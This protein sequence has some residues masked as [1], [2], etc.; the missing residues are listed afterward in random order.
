MHVIKKVKICCYTSTVTFSLAK[1][2]LKIRGAEAARAKRASH[3]MNDGKACRYFLK[4]NLIS[5]L[6]DILHPG[7]W[8]LFKRLDFSWKIGRVTERPPLFPIFLA[9]MKYS[10]LTR[11]CA[12]LL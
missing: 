12:V 5:Q 9:T 4:L 6:R 2:Y 1:P 3:K 8:P 7:L 11:A 10:L